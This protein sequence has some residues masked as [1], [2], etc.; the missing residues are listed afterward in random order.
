MNLCAP[1]GCQ[2]FFQECTVSFRAYGGLDFSFR[3]F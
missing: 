1:K 2:S 3:E